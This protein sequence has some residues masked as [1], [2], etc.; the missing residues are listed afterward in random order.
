MI[1][2]NQSTLLVGETV[3]DT[4]DMV[5]LCMVCIVALIVAHTLEDWKKSNRVYKL[6]IKRNTVPIVERV[7]MN[8]PQYEQKLSP[9]RRP[10]S[11]DAFEV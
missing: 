4:V 10:K 5:I 1:R 3:Y 8:Q 2:G 9:I 11:V 7:D 6:P